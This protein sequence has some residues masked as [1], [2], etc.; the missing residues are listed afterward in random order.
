MSFTIK[1]QRMSSE[2]I[3]VNKEINDLL[4]LQG[5]LRDGSSIV[6]PVILIQDTVGLAQL[7]VANYMTIPEFGRSYFI[8]DIISVRTGLVQI[9]GHTDVISSFKGDLLLNTGI[10]F[11]QE[12][13]WNLYLNDGVL[14][15]YQ[16][17]IV[18]TKKFPHGFQGKSYVLA[19][20]G[21]VG[22]TII[23]GSGGQNL[24]GGG[25]VVIGSGGGDTGTG[26]GS[27]TP[28]GLVQYAYAHIGCPYWWGTFGNYADANLYNYKRYTQYPEWYANR[29]TQGYNFSLDY[30]N[31]VFDCVGL[32]KGYR[33]STSFTG[34]PQYVASEDWDVDGMFSHCGG[35]RG[36]INDADWISTYSI[37]PGVL[38]FAQ[39]SDGRMGHVGVS[40]G[41]G[42]VIHCTPGSG[43]AGVIQTQISAG[44]WDYYGIPDWLRISG[45]YSS[46]Q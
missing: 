19:L 10:V 1:I 9:S 2:P 12:K 29:E 45:S 33:W 28:S 37:Y 39:G 41:D 24:Y 20:G 40:V 35:L 43:H 8:G 22:G 30:G 25:G 36:A 14:E 27:K 42:T 16:N 44:S 31:Q 7:N 4:E 6:D 18:A 17:P 5:V 46:I 26:N 23:Q 15:I 3:K 38:L 34:V 11:R 21:R 13:D 32:I